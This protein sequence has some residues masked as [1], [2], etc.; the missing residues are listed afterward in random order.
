MLGAE[1][2]LRGLEGLLGQLD[3]LDIGAALVE[4]HDLGVRGPD[5]RG[6][7]ILR[8]RDRRN[9]E[10]GDK[11]QRPEQQSHGEGLEIR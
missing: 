8:R 7:S 6:V 3:G 10:T 2:P 4:R 9:G 1:H 5:R 11:Q